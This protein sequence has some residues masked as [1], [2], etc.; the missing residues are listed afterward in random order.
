MDPSPPF[1]CSR[2]TPTQVSL[3]LPIMCDERRS[4]R[5]KARYNPT[6]LLLP[7]APSLYVFLSVFEGA[8]C[9]VW[10]FAAMQGTLDQFVMSVHKQRR[11]RAERRYI[12]PLRCCVQR[13]I[14]PIGTLVLYCELQSLGVY[15]MDT[16]VDG[17]FN[18][19]CCYI[20]LMLFC[21]FF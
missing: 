12:I 18:T 9:R 15:H 21:F 13:Q 8:H 19:H 14:H 3:R 10:L 20:Q 1:F 11:A 17:K 5:R 2:H 7:P 4:V 6:S 16:M